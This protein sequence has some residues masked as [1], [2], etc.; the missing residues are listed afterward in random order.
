[1]MILAKGISECEGYHGALSRDKRKRINSAFTDGVIKIL[2]AT[3][4]Y[5]MNIA[6]PDIRHIIHSHVSR[7]IES[8]YQEIGRASRDGLPTICTLFYNEKNMNSQSYVNYLN[9]TV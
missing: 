1:M 6:K 2:V 8:Y 3:T 7:D 9:R 4:S 5:G